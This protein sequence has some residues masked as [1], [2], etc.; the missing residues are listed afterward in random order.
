MPES[1]LTI[2][3]LGGMGPTATIDLLQRI[4]RLTPALDDV[5]HIRTLVDNNPQVPSRINYLIKRQGENPAPVLV[6]MA[7]SLESM[8]ADLLVMP[9]NTA[10]LYAPE[11][12]SA[13][14]IRFLNMVELT[15]ERVATEVQASKVGLLAST[16]IHQTKLYES[17][18]ADRGV[19]TMVP[20]DALQF[21][22]MKLIMAIKAGDL[23]ESNLLQTIV[24]NMLEEQ[25]QCVV[26]ACT[27]LSA[28][29]DS[30]DVPVP[31]IDASQC[32]AEVAVQLAL[33]G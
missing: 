28:L 11:I 8:G 33:G 26:I 10:H 16:A 21:Q 19:A 7:E 5:D 13:V 6:S 3:V 31:V 32:L 22:L 27:E 12:E 23:S 30:L 17:I 18:F 29:V 25:A 14:S 9:C 1:S 15:V 20:D 2:G 24:E 4:I